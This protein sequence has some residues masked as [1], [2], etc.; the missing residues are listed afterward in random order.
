MSSTNGL[1]H[2]SH[3]TDDLCNLQWF[4]VLYSKMEGAS[5]FKK[6]DLG[7]GLLVYTLDSIFATNDFRG[8]GA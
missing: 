4:Q 3:F 5:R 8:I 2:V 1:M 7:D 6:G